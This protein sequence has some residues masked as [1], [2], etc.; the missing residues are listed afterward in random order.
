MSFPKPITIRNRTL[1]DTLKNQRCAAC[2][3]LPGNPYN[4]ID[5]SHIISRGAGGPDS[6]WN[7]VSHCRRCHDVWEVNWTGFLARFPAFKQKLI[8]MG[9]EILDS[10]GKPRLWHPNLRH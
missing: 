8:A 5:P 3:Q 4:P 9:W 10:V 7:C 6:A 2:G 1:L